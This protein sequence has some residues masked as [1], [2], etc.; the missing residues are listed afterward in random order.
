VLI[1]VLG[2]LAVL[3]VLLGIT[4]D[5]LIG[6]QARRDLHDRVLA[7][8]ARADALAVAGTPPAQLAAEL[9]GGGIRARLITADGATYGDPGVPLDL[10]DGSPALPPPP[11]PPP[12]APLPGGPPPPGGPSPPR[13]PGPPRDATATVLTH[14]LPTGGRV[15]L[16]A[17]TTSTTTLLRQLRIIMIVSGLVVLAVAAL[18][19]AVLVRAAMLPLRRLTDVAESI[20]AG[21]RGRRVHPDRPTTELGRAATAFDT[22]VDA[23]ESSEG[24]ARQFLADA[25]HELRTPIAGIQAGAE[26]MVSSASQHDDDPESARQRRR[27]D[28]VLNEARQAGRLV[29]DMLDLSRIDAGLPLELQHCD[30]VELAEAERDRSALLAPS[31]RVLRTG[32]SSIPIQADPARVAQILANVA[33]NARRHTPPGGTITIDVERDDAGAA[34]TITD[35]GAGVPAD[36]RERIF[37]RLVRLDEARA[38]DRGGAGLGLP[39]ARALARAHCGDLVCVPH[40]PGARFRLRLAER[41]SN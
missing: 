38:R 32:A 14:P 26:Q 6:A 17:D 33:D 25:A 11:A 35:S 8:A 30:L 40:E 21:D 19:L 2:L 9:N 29:A 15:V 20:A 41:P 28:L 4:I 22:M 23:L 12:P 18:G 39:I 7:S 10:P 16:V 13:P 36:Q 5:V 27:A 3:L 31:L 37:E 34:V 24:R 1:G